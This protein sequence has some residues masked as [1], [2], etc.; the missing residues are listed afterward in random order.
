MDP[1]PGQLHG[2]PQG[3]QARAQIRLAG[4]HLMHLSTAWEVASL[5]IS[6]R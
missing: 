1:K 6:Q 4:L 5:R 2:A 3:L